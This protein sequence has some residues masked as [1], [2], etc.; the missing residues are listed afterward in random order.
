MPSLLFRRR[1]FL[2]F[3][4]ALGGVPGWAAPG[5]QPARLLDL[6]GGATDPFRSPKAKLI[7]F[8]FVRTDCPVCNAYAPEIH[9]LQAQFT[10]RGVAFKLVYPDGDESPA[11]IR[12][13]LRDFDFGCAAWRDP[14]HA[15]AKQSRV[16]VT[17]EAAVYRADGKLLYHGRIDD[18]F[19]DFG[20]SRPEPTR[21]DLAQALTQAV[22]GKEVPVAAGPAFGC[23][24]EDVK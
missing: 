24:I 20:K 4:L 15:F 3:L 12:R 7:A 19:V 1:I 9:R 21:R 8:I 23:F 6:D 18:R 17:P 11:T 16:S 13:H 5:S 22:A 10:A 14:T 2:F